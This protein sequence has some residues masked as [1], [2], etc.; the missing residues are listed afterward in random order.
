[1]AFRGA[2]ISYYSSKVAAA[3]KFKNGF[4][5]NLKLG[6]GQAASGDKKVCFQWGTEQVSTLTF[7]LLVHVEGVKRVPG[8]NGSELANFVK[9]GDYGWWNAA[10]SSSGKAKVS[11]NPN[12]RIWNVSNASKPVEVA[13]S[14]TV[15]QAGRFMYSIPFSAIPLSTDPSRTLYDLLSGAASFTFANRR[16]DCLRITF[17]LRTWWGVGASQSSAV[18]P[19]TCYVGYFP[20]YTQDQTWTD[21][22]GGVNATSWVDSNGNLRLRYNAKHGGEPWRHNDRFAIEEPLKVGSTVL[23]PKTDKNKNQVWGTCSA[24]SSGASDGG[25][26]LLTIPKANLAFTPNG[27]SDRI[28]AGKVRFAGSWQPKSGASALGYLTWSASAPGGVIRNDLQAKTGDTGAGGT[29]GNPV[30]LYRPTVTAVQQGANVKVTVGQTPDGVAGANT[31][32]TYVEVQMRGGITAFDT[33]TLAPGESHVFFGVPF[34]VQTT[35]DATGYYETTDSDGLPDIYQGRTA[36]ATVKAISPRALGEGT[37]LVNQAG[38]SFDLVYNLDVRRV[39][40]PEHETV[41]FAG[42]SRPSVA[43][44]EGGEVAWTIDADVFTA[45]PPDNRSVS[46]CDEEALVEMPMNGPWLIRDE[47]GNRWA[48]NVTQ[49]SLTRKVGSRYWRG[50]SISAEEVA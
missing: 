34:G 49:V 44:G 17:E 6:Y 26:Y 16:Y 4:G 39:S 46:V 41:K 7:N 1:M 25:A 13:N 5:Y 28:T 35:W 12:V 48:L 38:E 50:V 11:G 23:V 33:A 37:V 32:L 2:G 27:V 43:Y 15:T 36:T 30:I 3:E 19:V 20:R 18:D 42:R 47:A 29:S 22:D 9:L 21:G 31:K 45:R 10:N 8:A 24:I 40:K 14:A